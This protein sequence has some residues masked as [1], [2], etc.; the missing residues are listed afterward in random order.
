MVDT[1]DIAQ[2]VGKAGPA[3]ASLRW[4]VGPAPERFAIGR[5]EHRQWPAA[6]LAQRVQRRHIDLVDIGPLLPIDLDTHEEVVHDGGYRGIFE[7]LMVHDM[8][9]FEGCGAHRE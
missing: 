4:K 3:V 6:L 5:E 9:P 2:N 1:A 8:T 7:A